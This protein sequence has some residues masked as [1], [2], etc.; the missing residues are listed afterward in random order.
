MRDMP[1]GTQQ[2][3]IIYNGFL[4]EDYQ[5]LCPDKAT[6]RWLQQGGVR[7]VCA[8]HLPH[9]DAP[10]LLSCGALQCVTADISYADAVDWALEGHAVCEVLFME[11][12]GLVHGR[13]ATGDAYEAQLEEEVVG[14]VINGWRVKGRLVKDGRLVLSR[15]EG[16]DFQGRFEEEKEWLQKLAPKLFT[17]FSNLSPAIWRSHWYPLSPSPSVAASSCRRKQNSGMST[18]TN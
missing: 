6:L 8:G 9:G 13:L 15:N 5:P 2:P 18:H 12:K 3:S 7:R 11:Q 14:Q 17:E 16:W 4:G 10:L 1:D